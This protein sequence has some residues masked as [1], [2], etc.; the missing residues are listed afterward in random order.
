MR[1]RCLFAAVAL[2]AAAPVAGQD[3]PG[4]IAPTRSLTVFGSVAEDQLRLRQVAGSASGASWMIRNPSS[5]TP[6]DSGRGCFA[7]WTPLAPHVD[8]TWN[9]AVPV[10]RNDG[11]MWSGRGATTRVLT[12]A[13]SRCGRV[14]L[15]FAPEA[16]H[17]Q[18]RPFGLTTADAANMSGFVNPFFSGAGW[19]ADIPLRFGTRPLLV[20]EPGQSAITF[21]VGKA[22]IGLSTEAEWWGPAIR[23]A[24]VL[25]NHAAGVPRAY[26]GTAAPVPTD[27]GHVHARWM[28]GALTESPYFDFDESNDLRSLSGLVVTLQTAFDPNLTF[29]AARV[30]FAP[31]AGAGALPARALDV[32]GRWGEGASVR[33][34]KEG[35]GADQLTTLFARWVFPASRFEAYGEWARVELPASITALMVAP[36]ISQGYT[37]GLQWLSADPVREAWRIQS[38]ITNLEQALSTRAALPPTFYVSPTVPQ[39]YTQRGQVLGALIGPGSSAQW[40][41]VDRLSPAWQL[42]GFVARTRWH[43]DAYYKS[44]TGLGNWAHDVSLVAGLRGMIVLRHVTVAGELAAERRMN[45]L[46]QSATVG[47]ASDDTFDVSNLALRISLEPRFDGGR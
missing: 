9:S 45:Y 3:R 11:G 41:A 5:M 20:I 15:Q 2:V 26:L 8:V 34:A 32:I 36:Y 17:A 39:G 13:R 7:S 31:V 47:F 37:L 29:G 27:L 44:P 24:L 25:S 42:G 4:L 22:R 21:D 33:R 14:S 1:G 43:N 46:F 16:W 10:E 30:V 23:N 28:I 18:N 19:S 6:P 35:R 38:E 40:V 12:G